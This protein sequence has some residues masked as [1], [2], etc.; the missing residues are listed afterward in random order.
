MTLKLHKWHIFSDERHHREIFGKPSPPENNCHSLALAQKNPN[1]AGSPGLGLKL[2][3]DEW[4]DAHR[5]EHVTVLVFGVRIFGAHLAC[6]L[7]VLELESDLALV[8][9]R[10]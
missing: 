8:V 9:E 1:P 6:R 10:L 3:F 5:H 7:R 2:N 4:S